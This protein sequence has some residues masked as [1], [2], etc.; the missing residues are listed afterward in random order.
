[1]QYQLQMEDNLKCYIFGKIHFVF[2]LKKKEK[3]IPHY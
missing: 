2:F 1:M 3:K